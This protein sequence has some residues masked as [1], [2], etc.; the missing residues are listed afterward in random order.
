[1]D[2]FLA[3]GQHL[4][5]V[6]QEMLPGGSEGHALGAALKQRQ[7]ELFFQRLDVGADRRLAQ[8][9]QIGGAGQVAFAPDG[10]ES[11]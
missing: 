1:M 6:L 5:G 2:Q 7:A 8:A 3:R 9:Q 11:A 4:F 10:D